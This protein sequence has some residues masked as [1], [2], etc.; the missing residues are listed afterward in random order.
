M[1]QLKHM[2]YVEYNLWYI[3]TCSDTVLP[4]MLRLVLLA[5]Y[6][7]VYNYAGII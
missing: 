2:I 1:S 5:T 7:F 6:V 3:N 4:I